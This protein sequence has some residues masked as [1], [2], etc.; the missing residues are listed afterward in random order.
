MRCY[1]VTPVTLFA[2][3]CLIAAATRLCAQSGAPTLSVDIGTARTPISPDIYGIA[4]YGL[5][6]TFAQEIK[7]GNIRWGG[8]GTTRYNWMVD[9]SNS[10]FDW[11]FI[12]GNGETTPVPGASADL[13]VKTYAPA[14]ALITI[15][16]IPYVNKSSAWSCSFPQSVYG[17]QQSYD[18]YLQVNGGNC[19][20]SLTTSG[21]QLTDSNILANHIANTT[22][23]QQQWVAHLVSTFGTAANGGVKFY[24]LDNEPGGWSNTHRDIMPAEPTYATIVEYG[25][26]YAAAV[27]KADPS[28]LVLGPSDFTLGGWIGTPAQ[29]NNLYAGQYYLQQMA[30]YQQQHGQRLLDYFD[31]HYYF[32][33]SSPAAQLASTRTLWDPTY[34]GGTWVEQYDFDGPMQLIPRFKSW[35]G[36]YYPGTKLSIS[37]YSID[38]GQKS[39][40]DAIAE[41]DVLGIFGREQLDFADMWSPPAPTD[42]IAYSFRMF[43]NYDGNGGQFGDTAVSAVS[44]DQGTLSI[45]AAQRSTDNAVTVLVINKTTAPLASAISFANLSLPSSAQVYTYSAATLTSIVHAANAPIANSSLSYSFPGYSAVMFVIQPAAASATAT[46]TTLSASATQ[47]A[48]GQSVTFSAQVSAQS[49]GVPAGTVSF[50]DGSAALGTATL[51][52]GTATFQTAQLAAGANSVTASYAG[53]AADAASTS[54]A[55]AVQVTQQGAAGDYTLSLSAKALSASA[56]KPG[57]LMLTMTPTSG[58]ATAQSFTC[59]GLPGGWSCSFAPASLSGSTPQSTMITVGAMSAAQMSALRSGMQSVLAWPFPLLLIGAGSTR[60]ASRRSGA[61]LSGVRLSLVAGVLALTALALAGCGGSDSD[62][63]TQ[64]SGGQTYTVTVTA[65][66]TGA[67]THTAQFTLTVGS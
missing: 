53:D 44:S 3:F 6:A 38:S 61:R 28:A 24:Q 45:Y 55:V 19:G 67:A 1:R 31:E 63:G 66:G 30:A 37:E 2:A 56:S 58:V 60:R 8:D 42:P 15:P 36:T 17:A 64:S 65:T 34:N 40:V 16:I 46:T 49:G 43:R 27:K 47:A 23:L 12:G 7:V 9:S 48:V 35:I 29:Q 14:D 13:M 59:S 21:A 20:N 41:M 5:D 26:N 32:D 22:T 11:Y 10:G 18:P 33:V 57:T 54:S 51:S 62:K 50:L 39:I 25:Q 52:N 4:N